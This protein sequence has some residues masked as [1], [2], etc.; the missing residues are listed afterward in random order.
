MARR[1]AFVCCDTVSLSSYCADPNV[2]KSF[3]YES[4][5]SI[6]KTHDSRLA[7]LGSPICLS[8]AHEIRT[9]E[10]NLP[11]KMAPGLKSATFYHCR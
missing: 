4:V 3:C 1:M 9:L 7:I 2:F 10:N 6:G 11:Q 8:L 5:V